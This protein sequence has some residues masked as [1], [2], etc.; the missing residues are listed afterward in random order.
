[1]VVTKRLR[2][3]GYI[4]SDHYD[5]FREFAR[6]AP[7]WVRDGRL[8]YRE[9]VVDGIENAPTGVPRAP[10]RREHREDAR[11]G[12]PGRVKLRCRVFGHKLPRRRRPFFLTERYQRC[13]R[14]G[15]RVRL[16][17]R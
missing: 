8:R 4:I 12:R 1:M 5:R 2:I 3:Q 11:Q 17:G 7:E 9:T 16:S 15:K 13:E 10:A 14:C 6:E